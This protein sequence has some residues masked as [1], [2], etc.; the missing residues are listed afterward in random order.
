MTQRRQAEKRCQ[1]QIPTWK[2]QLS[3]RD[4]LNCHG[5]LRYTVS[6]NRSYIVWNTCLTIVWA[7]NPDGGSALGGILRLSGANRSR[8]V[9]D[10][11]CANIPRFLSGFWRPP[12]TSRGR[13]LALEFCFLVIPSVCRSQRL[14]TAVLLDGSKI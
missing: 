1:R 12:R 8:R 9:S 14:W 4:K 13:G 11:T 7:Q 6:A 2:R 10:S 3:T 5:V